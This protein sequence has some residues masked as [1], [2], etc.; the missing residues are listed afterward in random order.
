MKFVKGTNYL[1]YNRTS[2]ILSQRLP[3][4]YSLH[5]IGESATLSAIKYHFEVAIVLV[6][7]GPQLN[8]SFGAP[9]FS[10]NFYFIQNKFKVLRS[11]RLVS[12]FT[13]Y[14]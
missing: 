11:G 12:L 6:V 10:E 8:D 1:S 3:I 5:E 7:K 14:W 4:I 9:Q 13:C 2:H